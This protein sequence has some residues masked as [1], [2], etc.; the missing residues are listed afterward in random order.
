M[1]ERREWRLPGLL[2]ADDLALCGEPEGNLGAMMGRFVEE[3]RRRS[4]QVIADKSK[5]MMMNEEEGLEYEVFLD[6][7]R[8]EHASKFKYLM[9]F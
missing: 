1:E 9:C 5:V 8:L 4:L 2:Y 7:T 3:C 6:G